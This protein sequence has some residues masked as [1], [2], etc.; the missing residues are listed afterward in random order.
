VLTGQ[1]YKDIGYGRAKPN[2]D[3]IKGLVKQL[4]NL[5]VNIRYVGHEQIVSDRVKVDKTGVSLEKV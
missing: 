5:G 1:Q 4:K 2:E 3:K